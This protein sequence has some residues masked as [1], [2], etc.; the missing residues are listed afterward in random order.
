MNDVRP[1][2][3]PS[4][5]SD[6]RS[7][8]LAAPVGTDNDAIREVR[9]FL[10]SRLEVA[11][12]GVDPVAVDALVQDLETAF[13]ELSV[14][15]EEVRAQQA[16]ISGLLSDRRARLWQQDRMLSVM[17][18]PVLATDALG[19]VRTVNAAAARM[20]DMQVRHVL[21]KP[22]L[23]L[24]D[25]A[26][27]P[28]LRRHLAARDPEGFQSRASLLRRGGPAL[29]VE[30]NV[31]HG[32]RE[33]TGPA[34]DTWMLM[35][36][37]DEQHVAPHARLPQALVDL[38]R[39]STGRLTAQDLLTE[40]VQVC[41]T[42]LGDVDLSVSLGSPL[43]PTATSASSLTAQLMDG[44][45]LMSA[46]GPCASAFLDNATVATDDISTDP[47]WPRLAPHVPVGVTGVVAVP[48]EVGD[49]L[50]GALNVYHRDP[51][52]PDRTLESIELLAATVA[53]VLYERTVHAELEG[54]AA[55][56]TRALGSRA[57]IDQA[58]G[59]IMAEH[60][61]D[62]DEAFAFLTAESSRSGT[63]VR[64]VAR[65]IVARAHALEDPAAGA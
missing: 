2:P 31:T 55:D 4:P 52:W 17:P 21:G 38:A 25:P 50:V 61:L 3:V 26:G 6:G 49:Q 48:L 62:A 13:E 44:A 57:V 36:S 18:V 58:K 54:L 11:R 19:V 10:A 63:K 8:S 9:E 29:E 35:A 32:P 60:G 65:R 16:Q 59:M 37:P 15:E 40:V 30:V 33:A 64:E 41:V 56:M 45:Q 20:L 46:E 43:E 7:T 27:R 23:A 53:A 12:Q 39:L 24:F 47:R 22:V 14:A 34:L 51:G 42:A 1:G 5:D 28:A